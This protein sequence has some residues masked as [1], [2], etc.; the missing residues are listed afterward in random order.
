MF[1]SFP[2]ESVCVCVYYLLAVVLSWALL[3]GCLNGNIDCS[4]YSGYMTKIQSY[5]MSLPFSHSQG[6]PG[7]R[8]PAGAAGPIGL[9]GRPGPQG[10]P[11]PAGEKGAPVSTFF[12]PTSADKTTLCYLN[13]FT[14]FFFHMTFSSTVFKQN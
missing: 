9:S 5:I 14:F 13:Q 7:E 11:G 8:G 10:P 12:F 3:C 6:S 1:L 2:L 4:E